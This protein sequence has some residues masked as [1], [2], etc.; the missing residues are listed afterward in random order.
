MN[1]FVEQFLLEARDLV[2][3][4]T[5]DLLALEDAP[6]DKER[7]DSAFRAFHTLKGSAAIVDFDAMVRALHAAEDVLA[8]VRAGQAPVT[9]ALVGDGLAC[10]DQ[11]TLWLDQ[12]QRDGEP[13]TQ[14][15]AAADAIV[16]R[17]S[18]S[19]MPGSPPAASADP[20]WVSRLLANGQA[21]RD[22]ARSAIRYMPDAD[23]FFRGED[24]SA[25]IGALPG[26]IML[27]LEPNGALETIATL[28]PFSC[29]LIFHALSTATAA[30]VGR[31]AWPRRDQI[32]IQALEAPEPP[33][34]DSAMPAA[35]RALL[36]AQLGLL[37]EPAE[38]GRPARAAA[39]QR[40]AANVLRYLGRREAA[41]R[42]EQSA[43]DEGLAVAIAAMLDEP[44][45]AQPAAVPPPPVATAQEARV[46]RVDVERVDA[47]V[48][49]V[50]EL[51]VLKNALG[52][53]AVRARDG[54]DPAGLA[55]T[56]K[57]HHARLDRLTA[58][59]QRSVL[60]MRV[61]PMRHVFV[62]FSRLVREMAVA[63][64]KSVRLVTE[65]EATEADKAVVEGLFE[66][67][68]HMM[69]NA[70]DHG[71]ESERER[72]AAGKSAMA[73]VW[74]RGKREGDH[75]LIEVEDD[76]RGIDIGRVRDIAAQRG[77]AAPD[78][79]S[80]MSDSEAAELIFA[81]GFSTASSV[82]DSSG[83]GVGMD[84][85]RTSI[86]RLGGVVSLA[87]RPG[88]GLAVRVTLPFTV[89]M[90]RLM[91]VEAGGEM[92]G[93]PMEAVVETVRAPRD[94]IAPLGSMRAIVLRERTIPILDLVE[95]VGE[96]RATPATTDDAILVIVEAEGQLSGLEVDGLGDRIDVMLK[97][98]DGLLA[99]VH[100]ISGTTLL[101]DGRVL[102][103]LD[104]PELLR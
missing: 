92:F 95:V 36:E 65:G 28:D 43:L 27:D 94:R 87:N 91:I 25:L 64:G 73:T 24:P 14:A 35:A 9:P 23:C 45:G 50:G 42:L 32:D 51:T 71:V 88:L 6:S 81:P 8:R 77:I 100:G 30:E 22:Q 10:L 40:V 86:R 103:V 72:E 58:A 1:E 33:A 15:D 12:M 76:G 18:V 97:P 104:L 66:P 53:V 61:F 19:P 78:V 68:L 4:A 3:Q 26:L 74:L 7:L 79:I 59:L 69:R 52:H 57:D 44:A 54:E 49:L 84:A 80:A 89:M 101:G 13:P 83:R 21:F 17:L 75:V 47:M 31:H 82:T 39:A 90:T 41:E 2:G 93:L 70:V 67:L 38:D 20:S 46:L 56:L 102:I 99:G 85:V 48:K 11:V 16:A 37:A 55:A 5:G 29:R 60:S 62:R 63:A 96:P 98:I 34:A